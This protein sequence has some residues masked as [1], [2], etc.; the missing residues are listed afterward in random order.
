M[1]NSQQPRTGQGRAIVLTVVGNIRLA[2][3]STLNK[4]RTRQDETGHE[5]EEEKTAN[6]YTIK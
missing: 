2:R 3:S 6:K 1:C 4:T 5:A